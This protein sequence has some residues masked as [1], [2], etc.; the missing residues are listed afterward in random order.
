MGFKK[1]SVTEMAL[2]T[3]QVFRRIKT[4]APYGLSASFIFTSYA[5]AQAPS[6]TAAGSTETS[7]SALNA[8]ATDEVIV[9]G[10]AENLIGS[11]GAASEG[12]VAGDDLLVRPMLRVADLLEAVPGMI[13]AQHSGSGKANQYFLR[14]FNLDHGTDFTTYIDD[15]PWNLRTHGHGQ[16][17][18]DVN[19]LIPETVERIDYRK[20]TYRALSGDFSMAGSA[21]MTSISGLEKPFVALET[22]SYGWGRVAGGGTTDV[23]DGQLTLIGQY[24][25]YDGPWELSEDL[26]HE[27]IWGK[28]SEKTDYGS[29][30]I[31]LSGYLATWHPTEQTPESAFGSAECK[32]EY[33]SLDPSAY[34]KTNRWILTSNWLGD[35]WRATLYAQSYDWHMLSNPTY[36]DDG[37]INQFDRRSTFGGR[38]EQ[39]LVKSEPFELLVGTEWRYDRISKVGLDATQQG[40]FIDNISNNA[41]NEGS[42]GV[43][44]ETTWRPIEKLRLTAG[45][46]GDFYDF[47]VDV[48]PN[49]G[50]PDSTGHENDSIASPKVGAAYVI[51]DQVELYANWGQGFHSND[52]RGVVNKEVPVPGLV[53][54][55]GYESG[56][57]FEE[58]KFKITATY[59]WLN[60]DSELI[61]VGDSNS[62]EPKGGAKRQG[63]EVVAF[64][65]PVDWLG[66]DAVYTGSRARNSDPEE[67]GG[68][69]VEGGVESAGEIG[70]AATRNGWEF[71]ARLRYLGPYPLLPDNSE[72]AES[73]TMLNLRLAHDFD[74]FT[75]YGEVL[76]VLD[77]DGKDIVYYYENQF[78]PEGG[79]VSR[80]EEPRSVRV[81]LKYNF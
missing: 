39:N 67:A 17:Y 28:Y 16:G 34:G 50:A 19:G 80:A 69:Y 65:H 66:I 48:N 29:W 68:K 46:R 24:K 59:W 72:R 6:V 73:E 62:V 10:R 57:R 54:G 4:V 37:Q 31:S 52:A 76:N 60:L 63:Y 18:L 35:D 36:T 47:D 21:V 51:N 79:R 42:V 38:Y 58:G 11:A 70:L 44:A 27:S 2:F 64:W 20:G 30:N 15:V 43:Y 9:F 32:D 12:A 81:G 25:T 74:K 40:N 77:H 5:F 56:V 75:L 55:T 22:G 23:G 41:I 53:R 7:A 45:L 26:Q 1:F 14:G 61:F 3:R 13:A 8:V 78:D 49:S 33:C 71:S